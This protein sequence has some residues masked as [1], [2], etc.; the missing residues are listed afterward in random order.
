MSGQWQVTGATGLQIFP[1]TG[2][3]A[4]AAALAASI[5]TVTRIRAITIS[6]AAAAVTIS[7]SNLGTIWQLAAPTAATIVSQADLDLRSSPGG[8]LTIA[9]VGST[10]INVQGDW[11][12]QGYPYGLI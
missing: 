6:A 3:G 9:N 7:D 5:G 8:T 2:S 1:P 12:P 4:P 10:A 11:V